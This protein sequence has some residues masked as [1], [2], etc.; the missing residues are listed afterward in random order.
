MQIRERCGVIRNV[1]ERRRGVKYL[2]PKSRWLYRDSG[3]T[4]V[5]PIS[6]CEQLVEYICS[7]YQP[8]PAMPPFEV[9]LCPSARHRQL[10][11]LPRRSP[12]CPTRPSSR[13][14][15]TRKTRHRDGSPAG[16]NIY[17]TFERPGRPRSALKRLYIQNCWQP[18]FVLHVA[19]SEV[20]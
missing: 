11:A 20:W 9:H 7:N 10:S 1:Q 16:S 8:C 5:Y 13:P 14:F 15:L 2:D 4:Q 18:H 17:S 6:L 12:C 3:C 19:Y